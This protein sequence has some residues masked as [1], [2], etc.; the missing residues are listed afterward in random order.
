VIAVRCATGDHPAHAATGHFLGGTSWLCGPC[1]G[2]F[3][4][5]VV[6]HTAQRKRAGRLNKDA[7]RVSFYDHAATSIKPEAT[8]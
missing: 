2:R 1:A 3:F 7:A 8:S 4:A 6:R 5:W